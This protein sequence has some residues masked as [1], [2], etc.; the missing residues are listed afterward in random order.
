LHRI[1][2]SHRA[3]FACVLALSTGSPA[4][5][6]SGVDDPA[7]R[8]LLL[9]SRDPIAVAGRR[10]RPAP[11]GLLNGAQPLGRVWRAP[12]PGPHDVGALQVRGSVEVQ[13]TRSGLR[14]V[15]HVDLEDYVAGTLGREIYPSWQLETLKAQAV[16]TRTYALYRLGQRRSAAFD[17]GADTRDQVY[18]GAGAETPRI[19]SAVAATRGQILA[20]AGRPIL[21]VFHA[22]SG[23]QTASAEEVWG[24]ALPYLRSRAVPDE[25]DSP[26]TYWR[27]SITGTTL[28]RALAPLGVRLGAI[29]QLRVIDRSASGRALRIR[30]IGTEGSEELSGRELRTAL[31][32]GT[33]R[34]TL[35]DIRSKGGDFIFA[36]SGHG[37]GV[38]MSQWGAE[39]MARRGAAYEDILAAFYPGTTLAEGSLP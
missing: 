4:A 30:V 3:L 14:V 22:T 16:A 35:F 29:R 12:G 33:V 15:N 38:G 32:P 5:A 28:R 20:H 19:R 25:E 9:E 1:D 26:D 11:G 34:S 36:G 23:G 31:G 13:S 7:V 27:A 6:Q 39:A 37:H 21:S 24:R 10:I 8:V 17:L 18:G 2:R